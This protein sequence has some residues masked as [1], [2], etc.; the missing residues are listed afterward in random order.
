MWISPLYLIKTELPELVHEKIDPGPR[1]ANHFRQCLLR[2]FGK[3]LLRLALRAKAREQQ[4][5]TREPFLGGVEELVDQILFDSDVSRQHIGDEAVGKFVLPIDAK[6][7]AFLDDEHSRG[8]N[9]GCRRHADGLARE[10]TFPKKITRPQNRYNGFLPGLIH[11]SKLHTAFLNVHDV[12]RGV[13][14]C[15][16]SFLSLKFANLSPQTG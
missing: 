9:R 5:R 14:L 7:L 10:A 13:A 4:Q 3:N 16:D 12:L 2:Y 1:C 15:E 11:Y 6:H 8:R